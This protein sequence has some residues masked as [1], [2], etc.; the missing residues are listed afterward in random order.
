MQAFPT[1][2]A[3][4]NVVFHGFDGRPLDTVRIAREASAG[5][6][7]FENGDGVLRLLPASTEIP[8]AA[9]EWPILDR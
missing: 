3:I 4:A 8:L 1:K 9:N 5:R 6:W 2:L 7:A